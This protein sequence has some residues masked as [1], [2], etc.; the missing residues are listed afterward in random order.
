VSVDSLRCCQSVVAALPVDVAG[1]VTCGSD[2]PEMVGCVGDWRC[3]A[4]SNRRALSVL[5]AV[6]LG[7]GASGSQY[8]SRVDPRRRRS[9]NRTGC[10][11][12]LSKHKLSLVLGSCGYILVGSPS[13][14]IRNYAMSEKGSI[15]RKHKKHLCFRSEFGHNTTIVRGAYYVVP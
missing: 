6:V 9:P 5:A 10:V 11:A 4:I 8:R 12:F 15:D 14:S 7:Y 13:S 1:R 3:G 2:R